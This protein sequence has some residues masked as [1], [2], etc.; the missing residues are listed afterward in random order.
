MIDPIA[1]TIGSIQIKWYGVIM[2]AGFLFAL[3]FSGKI[4]P[5]RNIKKDDVYDLFIFLIP[6][7]LIAARIF[8]IISEWSYYSNEPIKML[9]IWQGGIAFHGAFIGAF[10]CIYIFCKIKKIK[11]YDMLDIIVV[12]TALGL[13][14]GRIG[15]FINQEFYGKITNLPWGIFYDNVEGKRHPSQIYEAIKNFAIF[16][17]LYNLYKIKRI[18]SG[19][20]FWSFVFLY[21]LLRFFVEFYK[22]L[23]GLF[24]GLT[25][26]Q[27]WS[28]PLFFLSIIFL[29]LINKRKQN[30]QI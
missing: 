20:I 19:N 3:W 10:L 1:F 27:L 24:L 7:I 22:D 16:L 4:A 28:I 13:A 6:S 12:P 11:V 9:Y 14:V 26:G 17:V 25:W 21:S 23:P 30:E 5:Q 18:R 2:A 29:Y 15:N 8:H